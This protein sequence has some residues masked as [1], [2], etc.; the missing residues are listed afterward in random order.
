MGILSQH[1]FVK[2]IKQF[3]KN[4][5]NVKSLRRKTEGTLL[6]Y[7][8]SVFILHIYNSSGKTF[9]ISYILPLSLALVYNLLLMN[10][11][12]AKVFRAEHVYFLWQGL[13]H[14][15]TI[16]RLLRLTSNF[17]ILLKTLI[18]S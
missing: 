6:Q 11:N 18:W 2:S 16:C 9:H 13:S 1:S 7:N 3:I 8:D 15:N 14:D 4:V 5:K 17:D 10:I 12:F